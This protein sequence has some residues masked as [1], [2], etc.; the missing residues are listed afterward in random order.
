M[1]TYKIGV[2]IG[3]TNT[4]AVLVS[5]NNEIVASCKILT[6]DPIEKSV[7]MAITQLLER[8][9]LANIEA[10]FIGTTHATNALLEEKD[11]LPIGLIRI[12]GQRPDVTAG[13]TWPK[14]L[15]SIVIKGQRTIAGGFEC[16]GSEI[17]RFDEKG[18]R[19]AIDELLALG[20]KGLAI[21][22]SFSM[23]NSSH[24]KL[25]KAIIED[26]VGTK[27]PITCS[28]EIS[29][30]GFLERENATILNTSLKYVMAKGFQNIQNALKELLPE[31]PMYMVQNDQS[32]MTF[33]EACHL[34]ILTIASGQTNS[35]VGASLLSGYKNALVIDVGGTS[36]DIGLVLEG[37]PK[38]SSHSTKI[39]GVHMQFSLPDTN[40]LA[41]GGGSIVTEEGVGP[42]SVSKN[43]F[44]E[45]L[46]F[47]GSTCTLTDLGV[48]LEALEIDG[49]K[50][51]YFSREKALQHLK[52]IAGQVQR[53]CVFM[54]E[55]YKGLP[56]LLVGGG[57][58]IIAWALQRFST[59]ENV[60]TIEHANVANA[61][62]AAL[63]EFSATIDT[64][65]PLKDNRHE[66]LLDLKNEALLK[67][68]EKGAVKERVRIT[69]IDITPIAYSKDNLSKIMIRACG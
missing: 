69:Q 58:P 56:V 38:R 43:L 15:Q 16:D 66:I 65:R 64:V 37:M 41:I 8:Q 50:T 60:Q 45:A 25:V 11:L 12:A 14:T 2:D 47:G 13:Y 30:L 53:A 10:V 40:S 1:N 61:F 55:K 62:G 7:V 39:G 44:K 26:V 57:A 31:C 24:E 34:P 21:V 17:C 29:G 9:G 4:D 54:Q 6:S 35:F 63:C 19:R 59:L 20:C 3:G 48:L 33:D 28:Y 46:C 18:A 22:G 27:F 42:L 67:A 23:L 52:E 32:A 5:E 68:L 51:V 36:S 49:A